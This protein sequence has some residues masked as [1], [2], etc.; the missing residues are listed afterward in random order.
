MTARIDDLS[1]H[2]RGPRSHPRRGSHAA[3]RTLAGDA[4]LE[5]IDRIRDV[6]AGPC[7][8]VRDVAGRRSTCGAG[9]PVSDRDEPS[10]A[11]PRA[12][13]LSAPG[14]HARRAAP[15]VDGVPETEWTASERGELRSAA[16]DGGAGD[17]L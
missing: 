12:R 2:F 13:A 8:A 16:R 14:A 3:G 9:A 15:G 10:C 4:G 6:E 17:G 11:D 1:R 7:P 5:S